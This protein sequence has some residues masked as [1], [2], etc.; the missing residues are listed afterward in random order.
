MLGIS[1]YLGHQQM[2]EQEAYIRKMKPYAFDSIFTSLHIPED[3]PAMYKDQLKALG[4]LANELNME[5]MA[6]ISPTSLQT[7]GFN[8]ENASE[9]VKWGVT[10]LRVDYGVDEKTIAHLSKQMKVA[11]NASTLT[12][13]TLKQLKQN[14]LVT[15]S[16]EA[17]HNFYPRPETG[18]DWEDFLE[19]NKWLK[20][21]GISIMAFI[22]G[23]Q[24]LRGPLYEKLPTLEAHRFVS[25]FAA[26]LDLKNKGKIEKILIGDNGI[27]EST[28]EQFTAYQKKEEIILRAVPAP[29]V[30]EKEI[31]VASGRHTNRAD[32]ARDCIRSVES[33]Q[34]ASIGK[35]KISPSHCIERLVGS[36]TVDNERYKRYQGEVQITLRDLPSDNRVNVLGRVVPEDVLLLRWIKGN[37]TFR[38]KWI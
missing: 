31:K 16:T 32:R 34:Y 13:S 8:W 38:I 14:G 35:D 1:V 23:D 26:Y 30:T 28:L 11:L 3:N 12:S 27:S 6:D 15:T 2:K 20:N 4:S 36:I 9:L 25:P 37:Q 18:L 5:L 10:G 22:P 21:E 19:K 33:R 17:W 7:L 29:S 24:N